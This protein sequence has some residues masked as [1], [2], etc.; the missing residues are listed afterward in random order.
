MCALLN[1]WSFEPQRRNAEY[2][3]HVL[4]LVVDAEMNAVLG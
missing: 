1:D 3:V 2:P 4:G